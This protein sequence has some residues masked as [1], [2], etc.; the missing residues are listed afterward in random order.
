MTPS[1]LKQLVAAAHPE[2]ENFRQAGCAPG[3]TGPRSPGGPRK[4]R[5]RRAARSWGKPEKLPSPRLLSAVTVAS[6]LHR[7]VVKPTSTDTLSQPP[8]ASPSV[9]TG[10]PP[11]PP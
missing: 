11:C 1:G 2:E 6:F 3:S 9:C 8:W 7:S 4:G 10:G 5:G